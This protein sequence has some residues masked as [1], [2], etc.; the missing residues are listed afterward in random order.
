MRI[1]LLVIFLI[2][3]SLTL[4]GQEEMDEAA[5]RQIIIEQLIEVIAES[6]EEGEELDYITLFE[7]LNYFYDRPLNLNRAT[8]EELRSIYLLTD[9]QINAL[10]E[11]QR[12]YGPLDSIYELQAISGFDLI[13]I[14]RILPFVT[15]SEQSTTAS[16]SLKTIL[17]EGKSDLF[18]RYQ[19]VLEDR[20]G[21]SEIDPEEL[22]ENPNSRY[23]GSPY[24][25][26]TRYRFRYRNNLSFGITAEKDPGEEFFRGSQSQ[27]YDFYSA[28]LYYKDRGFI[29]TIAL[30]DFQAQFGQGLA[31][32]SGLGFGKSSFALNTKKS[33]SGLRPYSSVD[34]NRFMRGAGI[35]LGK[36]KFE[37]TGFYSNKKIDANIA[38]P[39]DTIG[40]TEELQITSFQLSGFHRTESELFD[41]DALQEIHAGGNLSFKA[42]RFKIGMSALHTEYGADVQRNLSFY[43][44]FEFNNNKNFV[45]SVD[46]SALVRNVNLFGE[47]ARSE[48]GGMAYLNGALFALN[49]YFSFILMHRSYDK[50]FHS[51]LSNAFAEGSRPANEQGLYMGMEAGLAR[52]WTLTGYFDR[53]RFPWLRFAVDAPS[54]GYDGL[55]QLKYKP[56]RKSEFYFRFRHRE[57][58]RNLTASDLVI[59][60]PVKEVQQNIRLNASYQVSQSVKL[61]SR[62]ELRNY[63]REGSPTEN[64]FLIYQDVVYKKLSSPWSLSLRYAIF[65][66]DTYNARIYAYESDV[67]YAFS[68]PAYSGKGT[69]FYANLKYHIARGVDVWLRWSQWFYTDRNV[70]SSGLEEI[71]GNKRSE[72]KAQ[73][74]LR[75]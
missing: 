49:K 51:V 3:G 67:L 12:K 45:G 10:Q 66:T 38:N 20:R 17:S 40:S 13:T 14:Y 68:I 71:E 44:Q 16:T 64:G 63:L 48:S 36:G 11:H 55:L 53:F 29:R 74:R 32:W 42:D 60:Y 58:A 46:Y 54:D 75:F 34:E 73:L 47:V 37:L 62:V 25:F 65:D 43:N 1:R 56:S 33:V 61:K 69:R 24:R 50:D 9:V 7:E 2:L 19:Q 27:G 41:K 15:V 4:H 5:N 35:T 52:G 31:L 8:E 21:Y 18:I 70:I 59:N 30:G 26:Y 23:K 6:L 72:I 39:E 28:H 57:K 22:A